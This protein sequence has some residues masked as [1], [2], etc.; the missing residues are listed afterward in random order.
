MGFNE[1][2]KT[3]GRHCLNLLGHSRGA[4]V[5]DAHRVDPAVRADSATELQNTLRPR[6]KLLHKRPTFTAVLLFLAILS[7]PPSLR[8]RDPGASL[9]GDIDWVVILHILVWGAAGAWVLF[10]I[11]KRGRAKLL[12]NRLSLPQ[13][14]GLVMILCLTLSAITSKAPAL[15]AFKV[16]Q[17]AVSLLFVHLFVQRF[18][19]PKCLKIIF[20]GTALLCAVVAVCALLAPDAVWIATEVNADPSRLR[21]DLIAPTGVVAAFA[22]ILLMT[23][24]RRIWSLLPLSLLSAFFGLLAASLMRTAYIVILLFFVLVLLKRSNAKPLRHLVCFVCALFLTL[25]ACN[26]IPNLSQYRN[27]ETLSDLGDRIGLWRY[28]G[29]I[30]LTQSPW[31]GLGYYSASRVY[32]PEYNPGLGT[33]HSM[34]FEILIGGGI[35]SLAL[36]LGLCLTLSLNAACLLYKRRGRLSFAVASLFLATLAFGFMGGEIDSGPVAI[37]FWY[38]AAVLPWLYADSLKR[39][40]GRRETWEHSQSPQAFCPSPEVL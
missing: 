6:V 29:N 9:R 36:F 32:G 35:L 13:K 14:L 16:Y 22:I 40:K 20:W 30:T 11:G 2:W 15:S 4:T 37:C 18:G 21:G 1:L 27:P 17:M 39:S 23:G 19:P 25:Y 3:Q 26:W 12:F 34:F 7:G 31:L 24:A 10:Q 8:F 5:A 38:S 33:A 28:L